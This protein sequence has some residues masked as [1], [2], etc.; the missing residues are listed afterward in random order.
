[1]AI[2]VSY[3]EKGLY[4]SWFKTGPE[5]VSSFGEMPKLKKGSVSTFWG[6]WPKAAKHETISDQGS[7]LNPKGEAVST[8][9]GNWTNVITAEKVGS[10]PFEFPITP[11][12]TPKDDPWMEIGQPRFRVSVEMN[13]KGGTQGTDLGY[14]VKLDGLAM[15]INVAEHRTGDGYNYR[16][17]EPTTAEFP[18]IKLSR[19]A[20]SR[21]CKQTLAWLSDCQA[22]WKRGM[23]C[24]IEAKPMWYHASEASNFRIDLMDIMPVSW[25][26]NGFATD[27]K[28]AME[29]LEIAICGII[30][31]TGVNPA[32]PTASPAYDGRKEPAPREP[33]E[34]RDMTAKFTAKPKSGSDYFA[35]RD[36]NR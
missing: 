35:S 22:G 32:Y 9:K 14:W 6:D 25:S 19:A 15:K 7:W 11:S 20:T 31:P 1:M 18:N 34:K 33:G 28:I 23:T 21:G 5:S 26:T 27:G 17:I 12:K 3:L 24:G 10:K 36:E 30:R 13:G 29:V 4:P 2:Q 8:F 16:W